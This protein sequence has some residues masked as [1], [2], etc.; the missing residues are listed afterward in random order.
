MEKLEYLQSQKLITEVQ[1]E[2]LDRMGDANMW[3]H[4]IMLKGGLSEID[5]QIDEIQAGDIL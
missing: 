4:E 5:R 3:A 1:I 2:A